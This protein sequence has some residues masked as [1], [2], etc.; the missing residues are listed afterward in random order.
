MSSR[1]LH[2]HIN[3]L[4]CSANIRRGRSIPHATKVPFPCRHHND[5][6]AH[7]TSSAHICHSLSPLRYELRVVL[8]IFLVDP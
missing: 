5:Y 8:R 2:R 1:Q 3:Q 6:L 7:T 4:G